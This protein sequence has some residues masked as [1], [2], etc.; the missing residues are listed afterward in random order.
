MVC[1]INKVQHASYMHFMIFMKPYTNNI[2]HSDW[3]TY[4]KTVLATKIDT[5]TFTTT[6]LYPT[7][8]H[9]AAGFKVH[10]SL[11]SKLLD[12]VSHAAFQDRSYNTLFQF[13]QQRP[14]F[15]LRTHFK[16]SFDSRC[17]CKH[18]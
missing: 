7:H 12:I 14:L 2:P 3:A 6:I 5:S 9:S 4:M 1:C 17:A 10:C 15:F 8:S 13:H 11:P 16:T 18:G